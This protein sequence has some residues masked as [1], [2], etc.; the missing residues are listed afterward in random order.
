LGREFG[1]SSGGVAKGVVVANNFWESC[2]YICRRP[3][4]ILSIDF[5]LPISRRSVRKSPLFLLRPSA[6]NKTNLPSFQR[7]ESSRVGG[8]P[9]SLGRTSRWLLLLVHAARHSRQSGNRRPTSWRLGVFPIAAAAAARQSAR[10]APGN[11]I[12]HGHG[13]CCCRHTRSGRRDGSGPPCGSGYNRERMDGGKQHVFDAS[14][15]FLR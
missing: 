3:P 9:L 2:N 1:D 11:P 5:G 13:H 14:A 6:T 15:V 4:I 12:G 10:S 8:R 7:C